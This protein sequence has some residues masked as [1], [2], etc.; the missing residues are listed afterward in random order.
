M[1]LG[2]F[3]GNLRV[4]FEH[5]KNEDSSLNMLNTWIVFTIQYTFEPDQQYNE[6]FNNFRKQSLKWVMFS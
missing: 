2:F 4:R 5:E 6:V 3:N 1:Y